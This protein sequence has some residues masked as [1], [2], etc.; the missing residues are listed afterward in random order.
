MLSHLSLRYG[1]INKS[2]YFSFVKHY[3]PLDNAIIHTSISVTKPSLEKCPNS[4]QFSPS[5][6]MP[7]AENA[8]T[9]VPSVSRT[10]L[11]PWVSRH[12]ANQ[13]LGF[14]LAG[15]N[16]LFPP[17][18]TLCNTFQDPAVYNQMAG[19]FTSVTNLYN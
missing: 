2:K 9:Y 13:D 15:G 6:C 19:W 1:T 12:K 17:P 11:L 14:R 3:P 16:S 10:H 18:Q 5:Q 4:L 7:L 8:E